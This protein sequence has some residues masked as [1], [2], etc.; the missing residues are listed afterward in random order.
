M[1]DS[2]YYFFKAIANRLDTLEAISRESF[3]EILQRIRRGTDEGV[4]SQVAQSLNLGNSKICQLK[5]GGLILTWQVNELGEM[6]NVEN[7]PWT[8]QLVIFKED[9]V[10][11]RRGGRGGRGSRGRYPY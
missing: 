1:C 10:P 2:V 11:N 7:E 9:R 8:R 6:K 3:D 5:P 4:I